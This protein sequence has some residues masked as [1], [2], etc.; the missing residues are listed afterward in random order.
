MGYKNGNLDFIEIES[1]GSLKT[2]TNLNLFENKNENIKINDFKFE[3]NIIYVATDFGIILI[4]FDKKSI[5]ESYQLFN[6]NSLLS[7]LKIQVNSPQDIKV[8]TNVGV[9]ESKNA[10]NLN[11]KDF[12]NWQTSNYQGFNQNLDLDIIQEINEN[13]NKWQ[14]IQFKGFFKNK[15]SITPKS[16]NFNVES[17]HQYNQKVIA[18]N[19][20][21]QSRFENE[22][23]LNQALIND[24]NPNEI[25]DKEGFKW[26]ISFGDLVVSNPKTNFQK[27]FASYNSTNIHGD[28]ISIAFD[29]NGSLWMG[30]T[31]GVSVLENPTDVFTKAAVIYQPE[32]SNRRLFFQEKVQTIAFDA[33]N[34]K[35]IGT[36]NGLFLLTENNVIISSF[37]NQNAPFNKNSVRS[38]AID[39]A[40][41]EVFVLNENLVLSYR[42]DATTPNEDLSNYAIFPN[43]VQPN[44]DGLV[45]ITGLTEFARIRITDLN[46]RFLAESRSNG[47]TATWNMQDTSG[48]AV[49]TGIYFVIIQ[50]QDETEKI[51]GK[52][53]IVR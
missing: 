38:I 30:T 39:D 17:L 26:Y 23:W 34:R 15:E 32:S 8:L 22:V 45:S 19:E 43:P 35:W 31:N 49:D 13:G 27:R 12:N 21:N 37:T 24:L 11:L 41:G 3:K 51:I 44:F 9:Y 40:S 47:G 46:G 14:A 1:D 48:R 20:E 16:I 29:K 7:I 10:P 25:T 53:A 4:D 18:K 28:V 6:K 42:A 2:I 5:L 33:A 50:N 36:S 52:I